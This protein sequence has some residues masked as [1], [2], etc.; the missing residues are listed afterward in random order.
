MDQMSAQLSLVQRGSRTTK[1]LPYDL[2][3]VSNDD[4][5]ESN[6]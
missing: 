5:R 6:G 2:S 4:T 1:D 3:Q